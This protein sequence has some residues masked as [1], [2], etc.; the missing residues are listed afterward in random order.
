MTG[1]IG[2]GGLRGAAVEGLQQGRT[3]RWFLPPDTSP[4]RTSFAPKAAREGKR[5]LARIEWA[6][7][8]RWRDRE[9]MTGQETDEALMT[10]VAARDQWA[11]RILMERHML[12]AI[13]L[14]E[15]VVGGNAEADDIGQEAFLRAW[16]KA[17]SFDPRVA[18][19]TTW[20]Y[21]I[22]L[23]LALDRRRRP[24][25]TSG[26]VEV[27]D[28]IAS[29]APG[30]LAEL[31]AGEEAQVVERALASLPDR[32][33]AAIALFHMEG[34][35]GREAAGVMNL[36]EKAFESLLI[37]ARRTLRQQVQENYDE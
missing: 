5:R 37:R 31:V 32:Q 3:P 29:D 10:R 9:T 12:R 24:N 20:L 1:R 2:R 14:A 15:R 4:R 18:R 16:E 23:N 11:F 13:A 35:S 7:G 22:V 26:G 17:S 36:S 34:L 27:M 28:D 21:R 33:K 30:P 25:H 6:H 8:S 19:F